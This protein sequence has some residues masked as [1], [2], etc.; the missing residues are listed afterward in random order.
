MEYCPIGLHLLEMRKM[1]LLK[2]L[3]DKL[4]D[5]EVFAKIKELVYADY[6]T[7]SALNEAISSGK[8]DPAAAGKIRRLLT[9]I[10]PE[11]LPV[12]NELI[13]ASQQLASKH[14]PL[15]KY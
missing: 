3:E 8:V 2:E 12:F 14:N 15:I 4:D 7:K 10:I 1:N 6:S 5:P 13:I 11:V 9:G